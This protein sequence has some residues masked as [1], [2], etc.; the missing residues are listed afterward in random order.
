MKD[1]LFPRRHTARVAQWRRKVEG[2]P[3]RSWLA[4]LLALSLI[5]A[6]YSTGPVRAAPANMPA[7]VSTSPSVAA[8]VVPS[9]AATSTPVR[10]AR[11]SV[12]ALAPGGS[13]Q[14]GTHGIPIAEKSVVLTVTKAQNIELPT[15]VRDVMVAD[16]TVADVMVKTPRLI[17]M[18]GVKVGE[19]NAYFLDGNG[20]QVLKLDIRVE[21]DLT[22]VRA[23]INEL[24]P[25][26]D[27]EVHALKDDLVLTGSAPSA[28]VAQNAR[29]VARRFVAG[30]D[31]VVSLIKISGSQQVLI[32]VKVAEVRKNILKQVGI[33]ML[34]QGPN[35][36][37]TTGLN[38][39]GAKS[40]FGMIGSVASITAGGGTSK[41]SMLSSL[42]SAAVNPLGSLAG[43]SS[44][45]QISTQIDALERDGMAKILAEP[46]LTALS[47]ETAGFLAG[48]EV[49]TLGDIDSLGRRSYV[50]HPYGVALNFTPLVL[51]NNRIS[52]RIATEVSDID[53]DRAVTIQNVLFNAFTVNRTNT[54]VEIPS[55]ASLVLAGMLRSVSQSTIN[56]LPGLKDLPIIGALFRD[57]NF[58]RGE[59]E[60]MIMASPIIVRPAPPEAMTLPTDG[61]GH[62]GDMAMY[63]LN[64]L[65]SRYGKTAPDPDPA[66]PVGYILP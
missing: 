22:S 14:P 49:P 62:A 17:Y 10:P 51:D 56:G 44:V 2:L 57:N 60:L 66:K 30:E 28:T 11:S 16:P 38:A 23:A 53:D 8:P 58:T 24:V 29:A 34:A 50:L 32:Q 55:G 61:F 33:N 37:V 4:P 9:A 7:P 5:V 47:G 41:T 27:I 6:S 45:S 59:T 39:I 31:N 65:Y 15:S 20:R 40:R 19:T 54:T 64:G 12:M 25:N 3:E 13:P 35:G 1:V 48:G 21:R 63:L 46:T 26:A 18:V 43:M 52:L 42:A 36:A